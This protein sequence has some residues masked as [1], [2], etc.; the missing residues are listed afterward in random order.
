MRWHLHRPGFLERLAPEEARELSR[1]CPPRSLPKGGVVFHEGD[2]C[3][4]LQI[5]LSGTLKLVRHR[6]LGE[7]LVG[8]AGQG[9]FL[10]FPF[11]TEGACHQAE[12]VALS[13]VTL[14]PISREQFIQVARALPRVTAPRRC[15]AGPFWTWPA[16]TVGQPKRAGPRSNSRSP[17]KRSPP[18]PG[19]PG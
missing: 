4:A 8:L 18:W 14:C 5:V 13:E 16:A 6:P 1:I 11:L 7:R 17:R 12:A 15:P 10:G 3:D 2:P 19:S 9:D